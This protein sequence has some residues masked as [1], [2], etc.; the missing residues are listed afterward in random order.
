MRNFSHQ[1]KE[2]AHDLVRGK[3]RAL[4]LETETEPRAPTT[5]TGASPKRRRIDSD[6][7]MAEFIQAKTH[8]VSN[9]DASLLN[10]NELEHYLDE[11]VTWHE[12]FN[13]IEWWQK[14]SERY[15]HLLKLF[16]KYSFIPASS[17]VYETEFSYTGEVV[18]DKRNRVKTK[19]VND[20]MIARNNIVNMHVKECNLNIYDFSHRPI[21]DNNHSFYGLF[22]LSNKENYFKQRILFAHAKHSAYHLQPMVCTNVCKVT[23]VSYASS[24]ASVQTFYV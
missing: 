22:G 23:T 1:E 11:D 9:A 10:S 3:L 18:S 20:L 19:N 21:A 24:H 8:S 7:F 2:E 6:D 16:M 5:S 4:L 14:K 13:P 17:S 12:H 15:P